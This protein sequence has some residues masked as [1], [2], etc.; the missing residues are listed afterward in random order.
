[1]L[2]VLYGLEDFKKEVEELIEDFKD[3]ANWLPDNCSYYLQ[4]YAENESV[5]DKTCA[6]FSKEELNIFLNTLKATIP[7]T[8]LRG[9]D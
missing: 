9:V 2:Q 6:S 4:S 3:I 1:M 5:P 8:S 7:N